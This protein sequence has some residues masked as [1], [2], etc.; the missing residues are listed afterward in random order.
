M[1]DISNVINRAWLEDNK[2]NTEIIKKVGEMFPT[3]NKNVPNTEYLPRA[4]RRR[5]KKHGNVIG[6]AP[7]PSLNDFVHLYTLSFILSMDSCEVPKEK[8]LE[9]MEKVYETSQC[10]L[11]GYI[12]KTDVEIMARA[13]KEMFARKLTRMTIASNAMKN[14]RDHFVEV[15]FDLW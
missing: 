11:E 9:I 4:E 8:L 15:P 13:L 5:L 14:F 2:N 7:T 3:E 6:K 1:N 12:N 10:M